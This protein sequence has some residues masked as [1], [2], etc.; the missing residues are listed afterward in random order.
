MLVEFNEKKEVKQFFKKIIVNIIKNLETTYSSLNICFELNEINEK[1]EKMQHKDKNNK[2]NEEYIRTKSINY[3][4]KNEEK[5]KLIYEKYFNQP[6]TKE[7]LNKKID[8]YKD[9]NMKDFIK[10]LIIY[11]ESSPQI[12]LIFWIFLKSFINILLFI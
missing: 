1:Y 4:N 3:E 9:N 2:K 7:E 5:W 11:C 12:Y 8:E 6:F 10:K